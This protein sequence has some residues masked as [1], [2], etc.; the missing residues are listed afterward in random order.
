MEVNTDQWNDCIR[1]APNGLIYAYSWYLDAMADNW[2]ALVLN[3]YEAVM[4]LPWKQ[5]WG[6]AYLYQPWFCASLGVFAR[7]G[8]DAALLS[9]FLQ[10][11]PA[12]FRY[13]DIYLNQQNL[14]AV[15]GFPLTQR[16]NYILSL[17]PAYDDLRA[18]FRDNLKR[19]IRKAES[20][21]LY[22][23]FSCS[24]DEI[25]R[26]ST[27]T[28][29]QLS[30]I[31][32]G[33]I[34]RFREVFAK[35]TSLEQAMA[36]GI[37]STQGELLASAVFLYSHHRWY[38]IVVGNHPNGKTNGASHYLIDRFIARQAGTGTWLDF[39]GS[40]IRNL[41]FFYSSFGATEERYA[42]L[43]MN[44]LPALLRWLKE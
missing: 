10:Q 40:D 38:Y 29:Q 11:I 22:P 6:I 42:A 43:R 16:V 13:M 32:I 21:G 33:E 15:E 39:E 9:S 30:D 24:L 23:D 27:P 3:D 8:M 1:Q 20:A 35:A 17:Q 36:A 37:R 4:P 7:C 19:N 14:F 34:D 5:K 25:L 31:T 26:L 44:R 12:R 28:L 18:M 41:A 2:D